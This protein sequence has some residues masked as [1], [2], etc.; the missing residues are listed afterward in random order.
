[1]ETDMNKECKNKN[2]TTNKCEKKR[3]WNIGNWNVQ[4]INGKESE[5]I[6]EFRK[7]HIGILGITETKK[8]GT[9][10]EKMENG[11]IIIYIGVKLIERAKAGVAI[12]I[13]KDNEQKIST[14]KFIS[15]RMIRLD[16]KLKGNDRMTIIVGYGPSENDKKEIKDQFWEDMQEEVDR[17]ENKV[18]ILGDFNGSV[19][20]SKEKDYPVGEYGEEKKNNNGQRIF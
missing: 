6:D 5:L 17:A 8:K 2:T 16:L 15:E 7:A 4:G 3:I 18:I 12:V 11:D 19:G 10:C 13:H 9:G 1:M 14:W 20:Q